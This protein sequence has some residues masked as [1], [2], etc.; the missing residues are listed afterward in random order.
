MV[1][2]F[3]CNTDMMA[4]M[5]HLMAAKVW[6]GEPIALQIILQKGGQVREYIA[7]RGSHPSGT[8]TNMQGRGEGIWPLPSVPAKTKCH[9]MARHPCHR[10]N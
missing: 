10:W 6:W 4:T 5:H 9:Q 7:K 8:K 2:A 3:W 1:L